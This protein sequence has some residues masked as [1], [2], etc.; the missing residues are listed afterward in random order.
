MLYQGGD[1]FNVR[2]QGIDSARTAANS[3]LHSNVFN[4]HRHLDAPSPL[5]FLL[6]LLIPDQVDEVPATLS[7]L[8]TVINSVTKVNSA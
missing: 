5:R 6:V 4:T 3:T 2:K 1:I 8:I 7:G